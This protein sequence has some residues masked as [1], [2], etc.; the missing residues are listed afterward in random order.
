MSDASAVTRASIPRR[1]TA[2]DLRDGGR[3]AAGADGIVAFPTDTFYGLAVDPASRARPS[4]A[5]HAEGPAA[6]RGACRSIAASRAQVDAWC[7]RSS[8]PRGALADE[9]WPG[10][11]SL[12]CRR[13]RRRWSPAVH[14][15]RRHRRDPRARASGRARAGR[16]VGRPDHG[17]ERQSQRSSRRR[18]RVARARRDRRRS[19]VLVIDGGD[20]AGRRAVDD[21][22][23]ARRAPVL[24]RDGAIAWNRVLESLQAMN[25]ASRLIERAAARTRGARQPGHARARDR[26]IP[27][28]QL[29]EL[30]GLARAAGADVVLRAVQERADAGSGHA[31][32]PRAR[33]SRSAR[34]CD[35]AGATS[36]SSTTS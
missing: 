30:A 7:G 2:D 25:D 35:E 36:S 34:A 17:D 29:D 15:G 12:I 21:R 9:F 24:V 26:P 6:R 32:R 5:V 22:R 10:P 23:R 31:H 14:A 1:A 33:P 27:N 13:A 18:S 20:D 4:S 19:A 8:R 3:L 11:L 16:G 28:C